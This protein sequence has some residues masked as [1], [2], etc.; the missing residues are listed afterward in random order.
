MTWEIEATECCDN[1]GSQGFRT[2]P[3]LVRR[4]S[5]TLV[6]MAVAGWL[7]FAAPA[8][9]SNSI[10]TV[11]PSSQD[12]HGLLRAFKAIHPARSH[13]LLVGFRECCIFSNTAGQILR[14]AAAYYLTQGDASSYGSAV[15]E[16]YRRVGANGWRRVKRF[17]NANPGWNDVYNLG[18]GFLWRVTADGSGAWDSLTT[19][20]ASDGSSTNTFT[21]HVGY[22]WSLAF[23]GPST[24]PGS[25][26]GVIARPSLT[27]QASASATYSDNPQ[28]NTS[29]AGQMNDMGHGFNGSPR[30]SYAQVPQ[31]GKVK[32]LDYTVQ[33]AGGDMSWPSSACSSD[34][35]EFP[36]ATRL[37]VG[38]RMPVATAEH[39]GLYQPTT[40]PTGYHPP[41]LHAQPFDYPVDDQAPSVA[42]DAN[43]SEH[44]S[45]T[46]GNTIINT[47]QTLRLAGTLHFRLVGLWM[48]LGLFGTPLPPLHQD[49]RVPPVL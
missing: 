49:G 18:P 47:T 35:A 19:Q 1:F 37:L 42:G 26:A 45:T 15:T 14:S 17:Q 9:A 29:C 40:K 32:A 8:L 20:V 38:A 16:L 39:Y 28:Q 25:G 48:P 36:D 41:E 4:A 34:W 44:F 30:L 13:V 27:G 31:E 7:G 21:T 2:R 24:R 46:D 23:N 11:P 6:A 12:R 3:T 22:S 5:V 43:P 33:L 10:G